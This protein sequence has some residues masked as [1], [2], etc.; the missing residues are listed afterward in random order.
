MRVI[1]SVFVIFGMLTGSAVAETIKIGHMPVINQ[2]DIVSEEMGFYKKYGLD[3]ELKLFQTGPAAL[4]GLLSGDLEVVEA[5]GVPMLNLAAQNLPLYFLVSGEWH[6]E[7]RTRETVTEDEVFGEF[8]SIG[9]TLADADPHDRMIGI[10][11]M[12][13]AGT[14]REFAAEEWMSFADY[15]Q[16]YA[17]LHAR[18]LLSRRMK[19]VACSSRSISAYI[20]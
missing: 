3:V 14:V 9:A 12:T 7:V 17:N 13:A 20:C 18:A 6:G 5:G 8:V 16:N 4:Q 19:G 15:Q 10:H 2:S 1:F 11:P